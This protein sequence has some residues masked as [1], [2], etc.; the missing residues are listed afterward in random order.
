MP[1]KVKRQEFAVELAESGRLSA[2][3]CEPLEL[4]ET[5]TP[6]H[7][8]LAA[9]ARC[10]LGSLRYHARRA[11]LAISGAA[12]A[13]GAVSERPDGSWG[14]VEIACD[15]DVD[16]KPMPAD[17]EL[18]DLLGRAERGCFI[19]ASLTPRPL[20]RWTVNGEEASA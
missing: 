9:L 1:T 7:L 2:E 6:E 11:S 15:L 10:S 12:S 3:G 13:S 17:D 8:V 4:G 16:V 20:Y 19:G 18:A 14:F 5:W